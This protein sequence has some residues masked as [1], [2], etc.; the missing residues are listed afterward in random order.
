MKVKILKKKRLVEDFLSIDAVMLQH[1]KIDGEWSSPMRRLNINRGEA[2]AVLIY[3]TDT[4]RFVMVN[5]F[6]YAVYENNEAG[7]IDEI[8][9]G[10]FDDN[11]TAEECARREAIEET[12]YVIDHLKKIGKIYVSP[13]ITNEQ[14]S[15]FIGLCK[16]SDKQFKGGGVS[17][18]NEDIRII[19]YKKQQAFN[20][21]DSGCF[22][23]GKTVIALQYF[24][25]NEKNIASQID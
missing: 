6:R 1:T 17:H 20:M 10:V 18:E 13:G 21:L 5:Q 12:G 16:S 15:I 22:R 24:R 19:E 3:L 14:I 7:W 25:M 9:A 11:D 23:D 2:S 4:D 8:V